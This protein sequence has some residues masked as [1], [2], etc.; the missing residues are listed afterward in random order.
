MKEMKNEKDVKAEIKKIL[1]LLDAWYFM[2]VQTG[3]G[4]Q[5][6]PDFIVCYN[7]N[8]IG[9]EAK[10]GKNKESAWQAKQGAAIGMAGGGYMVIHDKNVASLQAHLEGIGALMR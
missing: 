8:F 9:I 7:G 6:I 1:I 5:G 3:Y 10:F 4:V 2:P